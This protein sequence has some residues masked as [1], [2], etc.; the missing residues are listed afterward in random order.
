L[1]RERKGG[2]KVT[3]DE[4]PERIDAITTAY[5]RLPEFFP[6]GNFK[7]IDTSD[8]DEDCVFDTCYDYVKVAI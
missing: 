1:E 8:M 2:E 6:N 4:A 7:I 3:R 5:R